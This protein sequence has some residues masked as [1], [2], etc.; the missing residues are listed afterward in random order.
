MRWVAL[1]KFM[2][3]MQISVKTYFKTF[4]SKFG[5]VLKGLM[6]DV[7]CGHGYIGSRIMWPLAMLSK[8]NAYLVK[9]Q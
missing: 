9:P 2:K 1:V 8:Q 7:V 5:E 3:E 4:I 6:A